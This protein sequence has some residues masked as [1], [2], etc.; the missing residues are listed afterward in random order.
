[1]AYTIFSP[2]L[3]CQPQEILNFPI[4]TL[5]CLD[6]IDQTIVDLFQTYKREIF[7]FHNTGKTYEEVYNSNDPK[8]HEIQSCLDVFDQLSG[9]KLA[10]ESIELNTWWYELGLTKANPVKTLPHLEIGMKFGGIPGLRLMLSRFSL[11]HRGLTEDR[12]RFFLPNRECFYEQYKD[13]NVTTLINTILRHPIRN[14][15]EAGI[16]DDDLFERDYK[17]ACPM[18]TERIGLEGRNYIL[19]YWGIFVK[20]QMAAKDRLIEEQFLKIRKI[21]I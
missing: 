16:C 15:F 12:R 13:S 17:N 14:I 1:M 7:C 20:N 19:R 21:V 9:M 3:I 8:Y 4:D 18:I 6:E 5:S 10:L 2:E 11:M